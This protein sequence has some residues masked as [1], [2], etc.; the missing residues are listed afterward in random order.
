MVE[1]NEQGGK[2]LMVYTTQLTATCRSKKHL[3]DQEMELITEVCLK[4]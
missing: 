1:G 2:F 3:K 4:W